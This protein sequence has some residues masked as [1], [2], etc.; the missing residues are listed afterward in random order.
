MTWGFK[1]V[2][3]PFFPN[4]YCDQMIGNITEEEGKILIQKVVHDLLNDTRPNT[5]EK[6]FLYSINNQ[7]PVRDLSEKQLSVLTKI[8]QKYLISA[9]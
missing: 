2:D 4:N 3:K 1:Y 8:K 5:W 9:R 6:E 7:L